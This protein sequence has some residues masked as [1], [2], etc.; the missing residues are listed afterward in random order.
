[1]SCTHV[2]FGSGRS[3]FNRPHK[4]HNSSMFGSPRLSKFKMNGWEWIN[5][6]QVKDPPNEWIQKQCLWQYFSQVVNL[7]NC[8]GELPL[9]VPQAS[10]NLFIYLFFI[11]LCSISSMRS[12][13]MRGII[14]LHEYFAK[15]FYC[16]L[17]NALTP[18]VDN[19]HHLGFLKQGA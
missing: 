16:E 14:Y 4:T 1:M 12:R 11:S 5:Q 15:H 17:I 19:R 13:L 10:L 6:T 2:L 18:H 9:S 3:T 8:L 7:L